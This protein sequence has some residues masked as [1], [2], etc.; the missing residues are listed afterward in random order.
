MTDSAVQ[1]TRRYGSGY[2]EGGIGRS[3]L[4][5]V[6][7]CREIIGKS[8]TNGSITEYTAPVDKELYETDAETVKVLDTVVSEARNSQHG[9]RGDRDKK[10]R[11]MRGDNESQ[12]G[13]IAEMYRF[14]MAAGEV[15]IYWNDEPLEYKTTCE[16]NGQMV[17]KLLGTQT[18]NC[19]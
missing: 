4:A 1:V 5:C 13:H 16:K 15:R 19:K 8:T 11:H 17:F 10:N 6:T 14:F 3:V 7:N 18:L 12:Q 9:T 2:F